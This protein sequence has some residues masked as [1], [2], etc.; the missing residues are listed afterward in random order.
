MTTFFDELHNRFPDLVRSVEETVS[1]QVV[2]LLSGPD[3]TA[4]VRHFLDRA[5]GENRNRLRRGS[6]EC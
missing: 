6:G 3:V 2:V 1:D 5:P 4:I